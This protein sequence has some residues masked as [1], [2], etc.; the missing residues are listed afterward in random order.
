MNV[1]TDGRTT[2]P[3][4]EH[5]RSYRD[6]TTVARQLVAILLLFV[7]CGV[8]HSRLSAAPRPS[9]GATAASRPAE[10]AEAETCAV[11][12]GDLVEDFSRQPHVALLRATTAWAQS[13]EGCA[14]CHANAAVHADSADPADVFGF[15]GTTSENTRVCLDCHS[16]EHPRFARSPH[17]RAG[18]GCLDCHAV[19]DSVNDPAASDVLPARSGFAGELAGRSSATCAECHGAVLTTFAFTEHHRLLEGSLE[20]SD[21]HDPH[22]PST[23]LHLGSARQAVCTE[24]HVDKQGPFVFEHG[25]QQVEGCTACHSPHGSPNRHLLSFQQVAE[26]CYSC[27]AQVPGFHT[28]F[29]ADT[30]CTSCHSQI[31]GSNLHPAFL[32]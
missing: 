10:S 18:L 25:A 12:H 3:R 26:Q 17:A 13:D 4:S 19:H 6:S 30:Q 5:L 22:G 9:A 1:S 7:W 32:Q 21:C 8:G 31:H 15:H 2:S 23:R 20:C 24:C 11:C 28:R 14:S 27:H 29:T 16:S